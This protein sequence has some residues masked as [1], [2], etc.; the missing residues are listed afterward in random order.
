L[1]REQLPEGGQVR[2]KYVAVD[3]DFNAILNY[4]ESIN[5]VALKMEVYVESDTSMQQDA[6]IQYYKVA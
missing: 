5:R 3:C 1:T 6:E 2:P 4:G